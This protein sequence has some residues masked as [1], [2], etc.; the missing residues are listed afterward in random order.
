MMRVACQCCDFES[1]FLMSNNDDE[2]AARTER[3]VHHFAPPIKGW[4]CESTSA[5]IR[6]LAGAGAWF[7]HNDVTTAGVCVGGIFVW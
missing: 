1:G 3:Q 4:A 2:G 6:P 7:H 5:A